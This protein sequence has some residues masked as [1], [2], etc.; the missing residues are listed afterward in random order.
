[1]TKP[2]VFGAELHEAATLVVVA[3]ATPDVAVM[4][5]AT[6]IRLSTP[7]TSAVARPLAVI[8]NRRPWEW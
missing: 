1:M 7:A 6:A 3:E 4:A 5:A 8:R 2:P